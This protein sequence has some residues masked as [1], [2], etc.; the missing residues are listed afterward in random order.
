MESLL[1]AQHSGMGFCG[2]EENPGDN[3][4]AFF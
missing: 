2:L 4:E 3:R 1:P